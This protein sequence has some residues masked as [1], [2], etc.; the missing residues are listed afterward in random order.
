LGIG[1][2]TEFESKLIQAAT[3]ELKANIAKGEKFVHEQY[4][5]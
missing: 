4:K 5:K 2:I 3:K 1:K